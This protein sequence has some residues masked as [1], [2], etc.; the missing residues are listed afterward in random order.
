MENILQDFAKPANIT[1][2]GDGDSNLA[3]D[4]T[5]IINQVIAVLGLAC[6]I[7]MIVGGVNYMTSNGDTGKTEK[8]KKIILYGLIG[9]IICALSFTIVNFAISNILNGESSETSEPSGGGD[10]ESG[11]GGT[12]PTVDETK[13]ETQ[14][15]KK[16][17]EEKEEAN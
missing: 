14:D 6:V 15:L 4:V 11:S 13:D 12:S 2:V 16:V 1:K 9:L 3:G 8:G 7:V 5:N 10:S 17:Q